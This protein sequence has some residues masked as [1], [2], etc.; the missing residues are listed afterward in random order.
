MLSSQAYSLRQ[1]SR[2]A[3]S[4]SWIAGYTNAIAVLFCAR[5]VSHMSGN[6]TLV[7]VMLSQGAWEAVKPWATVLIAFLLGAVLSAVMTETA[8]RWGSRGR[9]TSRTCV[10]TWNSPLRAGWR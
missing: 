8:K 10:P 1:K 6:A 9:W 3:I 5:T 2:L 7:S 4:L